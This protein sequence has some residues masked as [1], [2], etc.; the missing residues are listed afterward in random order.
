MLNWGREHL[1]KYTD[2]RLLY[3]WDTTP[4]S[5]YAQL[6]YV[7]R[8]DHTEE[9]IEIRWDRGKN[10]VEVR[11]FNASHVVLRRM[12]RADVEKMR[13]YIDGKYYDGYGIRGILKQI[14]K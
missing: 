11:V 12:K 7:N 8:E 2:L 4:N 6:R 3:W 10:F 13:L 14:L 5:G 1:T 9:K